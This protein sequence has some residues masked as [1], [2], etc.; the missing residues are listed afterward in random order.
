[1]PYRIAA[2]DVAEVGPSIPGEQEPPLPDGKMRAPQKASRVHEASR[3]GESRDRSQKRPGDIGPGHALLAGRQG[4][5]GAL[6]DFTP[7]A[8]DLGETPTLAQQ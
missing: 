1:M 4:A 6:Q 8:R 5:I 7:V 2:V 3:A